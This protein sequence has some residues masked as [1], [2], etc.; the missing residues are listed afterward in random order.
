MCENKCENYRIF[1][2]KNLNQSHQILTGNYGYCSEV[3]TDVRRFWKVYLR[4]Y[5]CEKVSPRLVNT[6]PKSSFSV[7]FSISS[8]CSVSGTWS[9]VI[10]TGASVVFAGSVGQAG[11]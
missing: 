6:W 1:N 11:A 3:V 4:S 8:I 10:T 9:S 2:R 7:L 5:G